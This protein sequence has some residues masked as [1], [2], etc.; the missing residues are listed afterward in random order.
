MGELFY[1]LNP[2]FMDDGFYNATDDG[3]VCVLL[4]DGKRLSFALAD[5]LVSGGL[6]STATLAPYNA[7]NA[8]GV[9]LTYTGGDV[10]QK[11]VN[12]TTSIQV[13][14]AEDG[15]STQIVSINEDDACEFKIQMTSPDA[16]GSGTPPQ[17]S[18]SSSSKSIWFWVAVIGGPIV[19]VLVL[20]AA[21]GGGGYYFYTQ[22]QKGAYESI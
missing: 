10:C 4:A 6:A 7:A 20:L 19:G 16:C 21:V 2:L 22:K 3:A 11:G 12:Y 9:T 15:N 18:S 13:K 17:S 8:D 1:D 14:C 5:G